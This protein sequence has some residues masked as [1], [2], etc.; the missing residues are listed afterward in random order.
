MSQNL[1][2]TVGSNPLPV[3]ISILAL[4]PKCVYLVHTPDVV[5]IVD[6]VSALLH[7]KLDGCETRPVLVREHRSA[8]EIR[9]ALEN[10]KVVDGSTSINYT[11]GTKLMAVHSRAFWKEKGGKER[12]ASY[13]GADGR[14]YFDDPVIDPR[15][16]ENLPKLTLGDLCK[17]HFGE[18][19]SSCADEHLEVKR[20]ALSRKIR[21]TI[22]DKDWKPYVDMLPPLYGDGNGKIDLPERGIKGLYASWNASDEK[23]FKPKS[24]FTTMDLSA[25]FSVLRVTASNLDRF[26]AWLRGEEYTQANNK[27]QTKAR[28]DD[29]AWLYGKW[30]EVWLAGELDRAKLFDE[31]HQ[32]VEIGAK[33]NDCEMDVIGIR[34]FRVF[35]FSCTVDSRNDLVKSKLFEAAN[36]TARIGGEHARA[37]MVCLHPKPDEVLQT[38]REEHWEG[39]DRLRL[40]GAPHVRGEPAACNLPSGGSSAQE[41][42]L[43]DGIRRWVEG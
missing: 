38:V 14:L 42:T 18:P 41:V 19:P 25:L 16:G 33:P 43:L 28:R 6:R 3:A 4:K 31:V 20:L 17:L 40:F 27:K 21:E 11:G 15:V 35:L 29:A 1:I 12:N 8:T 23:N 30:L 7:D 5:K 9:K 34:G 39:Y 2:V 24:P 26:S 36:R 13:L 32:G 10:L 37:A 22:V